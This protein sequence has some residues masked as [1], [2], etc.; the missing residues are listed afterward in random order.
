MVG[1]FLLLRWEWDGLYYF[2]VILCFDRVGPL[3]LLI[4]LETLLI[5]HECFLEQKVGETFLG[6]LHALLGEADLDDAYDLMLTFFPLRRIS[7]SNCSKWRLKFS[8]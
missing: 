3:E 5:A 6:D 1:D 2:D 7:S 8:N 4:V